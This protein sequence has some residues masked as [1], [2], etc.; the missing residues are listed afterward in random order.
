MDKDKL[1]VSDAKSHLISIKSIGTLKN[2]DIFSEI[3]VSKIAITPDDIIKE[4]SKNAKDIASN[5]DIY[6]VFEAEKSRVDF[7][8]EFLES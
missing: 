2:P 4:A 7:F 8:Y 5:K 6:L 3:L 1:H